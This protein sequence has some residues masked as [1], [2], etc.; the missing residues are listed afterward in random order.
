[1]HTGAGFI[2]CGEY[3]WGTRRVKGGLFLF[4]FSFVV[5]GPVTQ[6]YYS[7]V[8]FFYMQVHAHL[9]PI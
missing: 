6:Y 1:M 9:I 2:D 4:S 8:L 5:F 7:A 3:R